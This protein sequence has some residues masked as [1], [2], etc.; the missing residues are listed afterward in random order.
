VR[1]QG[2]HAGDH[3]R[4]GLAPAAGRA[5]SRDEAIRSPLAPLFLSA[6]Q[7]AGRDPAPLC[8]RLGL[9]AAAASEREVLIDAEALRQLSEEAAEAT[10]DAFLGLHLAERMGRGTYGVLEHAATSAPHLHGA[11]ER[12]DR[13]I[14][15]VNPLA[16]FSLA[17]DG[18]E[19]RVDHRM[20]GG[21]PRM[22]RHVQECFIALLAQ[23]GRQVTAGRFALSRVWFAHPRPPR[24]DELEAFFGTAL[25]GFDRQTNGFAFATSLLTVPCATADASLLPILDSHAHLLLARLPAAPGEEQLLARLRERLMATLGQGEASVE[26]A[27]AGLH[28]ST[29]TLQR[30]LGEAGTRFQAVLDEVRREL[31]DR[32]LDDPRLGLG[33]VAFLLGYSEFRAFLRAYKRWTGRTPGKTRRQR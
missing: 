32:Y 2:P 19:A 9:P 3:Q 4:L 28:L 33:E 8:R 20:E 22:G 13:Y 25:V 21:R 27:A 12:L 18:D 24:T 5:L 6:L 17:I 14:R 29:R 30:R 11:L 10:G 16:T 26:Q 23:L 15:L 31:A 1:R 7:R